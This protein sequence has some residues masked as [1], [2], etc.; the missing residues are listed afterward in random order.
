MTSTTFQHLSVLSSGGTGGGL[1]GLG[2][3]GSDMGLLGVNLQQRRRSSAAVAVPGVRERSSSVSPASSLSRSLTSALACTPPRTVARPGTRTLA[4]PAVTRARSLR[5][6]GRD[7]GGDGDGDG[8]D[9]GGGD[10]FGGWDGGDWRS[11]GGGGD[12]GGSNDGGPPGHSNSGDGWGGLPPWLWG[13]AAF[14]A[15]RD[16]CSKFEHGTAG[17]AA[18]SAASTGGTLAGAASSI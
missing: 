18:G 6:R 11:G 17:A 5:R 1:S 14:M 7:R 9:F 4:A 16:I 12:F 10:D 8:E 2:G 15:S 13:G 3:V